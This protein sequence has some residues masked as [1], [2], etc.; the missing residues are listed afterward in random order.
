L[1]NVINYS[2][3]YQAWANEKHLFAS[4]DLPPVTLA[5]TALRTSSGF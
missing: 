2:F 3:I 1:Q 4:R 5:W